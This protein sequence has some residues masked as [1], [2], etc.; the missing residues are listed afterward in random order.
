MRERGGEDGRYA[1]ATLG[2]V[3]KVL[4]PTRDVMRTRAKNG[5]LVGRRGGEGLIVPALRT[6][7]R[8]VGDV[9]GEVHVCESGTTV[10]GVYEGPAVDIFIY[11]EGRLFVRMGAVDLQ[12]SLSIYGN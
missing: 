4:D 12:L 9:D 8:R 2:A 6:V 5:F 1:T 11:R 3:E 10:V 7:E